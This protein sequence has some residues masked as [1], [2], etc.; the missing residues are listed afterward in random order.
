MK[1][2]RQQRLSAEEI[3]RRVQDAKFHQVGR[4]CNSFRYLTILINMGFS[5][6]G[7][8]NNF[9]FYIVTDGVRFK[10]S[11]HTVGVQ[12]RFKRG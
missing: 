5:T 4:Q 8:K 3:K 9:K 11:I 2:K 7:G 12:G 6:G 10:R 1:K